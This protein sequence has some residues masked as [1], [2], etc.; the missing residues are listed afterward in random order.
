MCE[1]TVPLAAGGVKGVSEGGRA[2]GVR[3]G[4]RLTF[5]VGKRRLPHGSEAVVAPGPVYVG[6]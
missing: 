4:G 2:D 3:D 1:G 6:E 5:A